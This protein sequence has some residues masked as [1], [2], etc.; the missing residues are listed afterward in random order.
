MPNFKETEVDTERLNNAAAAIDNLISEL[1]KIDAT[2]GRN[3][4]PN[5]NECWQGQAKDVFVEKF[6]PFATELSSLIKSHVELNEQLANAAIEYEKA[7]TTAKTT[8][9][10]LPK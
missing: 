9:A 8:V 5:L 4:L 2:V 1:Q 10:K 7:D 3:V 6:T